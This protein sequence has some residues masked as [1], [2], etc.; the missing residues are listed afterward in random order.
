[1]LI[2]REPTT[3]Q[4]H[5]DLG[6]NYWA[7]GDTAR[8]RAAAGK[9]ISLDSAFYE[10]YH[11]LAWVE[12][13]AGNATAARQWLARA[14]AVGGDFWLRQTLEGFIMARSGDTVGA[15][16]VLKALQGD[17]RLAQQGLLAY[18]VGDRNAMYSFWE[19]AID[20]HDVDAIWILNAVPFLRPLRNEPR[21]Q[22]LLERLGLPKDLR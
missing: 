2:D 22:G 21:Y 4:W 17:P 14:T 9:A 19:R 13:D 8:T 15:R 3:A 16:R 18:A 20:A 12:A 10:P 6:W 5:S 1:M 11:M 7:A